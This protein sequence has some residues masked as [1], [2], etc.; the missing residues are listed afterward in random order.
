MIVGHASR[1]LCSPTLFFLG[2]CF[3]LNTLSSG[4]RAAELDEEYVPSTFPHIFWPHIK[5]GFIMVF[6]IWSQGEDNLAG[7]VGRE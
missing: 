2:L 6:R 1:S 7:G 5:G 4:S 3:V